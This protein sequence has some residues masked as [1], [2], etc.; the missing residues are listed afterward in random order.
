M[1]K[2]TNKLTKKVYLVRDGKVESFFSNFFEL[3][4]MEDI[5]NYFDCEYVG[6]VWTEDE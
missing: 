3:E 1:W 6:E 4:E 2:I 5:R